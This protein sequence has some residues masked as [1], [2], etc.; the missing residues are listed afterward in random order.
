MTKQS[1]TVGQLRK[2]LADRPDE[3]DIIIQYKPAPGALE[4]TL[5]LADVVDEPEL[6]VLVAED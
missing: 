1:I 5:V 6:I 2:L 3:T 4:Y